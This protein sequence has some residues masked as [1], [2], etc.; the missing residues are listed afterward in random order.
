MKFLSL[1]LLV[2]SAA[3]AFAISPDAACVFDHKSYDPPQFAIPYRKGLH[4]KGHFGCEYI[5]SCKGKA[6]RVMHI[7]DEVHFDTHVS[8]GTGGPA[9]AKW[10]ICPFSV[11]P[12]SWKPIR[13]TGE[14]ALLYGAKVIAYD[15]EIDYSLHPAAQYFS[16]KDAK[17]VNSAEIRA[18]AEQEC[19]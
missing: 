6:R 12:D 19:K 1:L 5:C 13:T 2:F 11:Q 14:D 16:P 10:F 18:W 8:E 9:R 15:A 4:V 3:Q 17:D 7:L